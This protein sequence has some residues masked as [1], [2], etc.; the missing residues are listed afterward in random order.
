MEVNDPSHQGTYV[1]F[2]GMKS[3]LK[4]CP[5]E[6]ISSPCADYFQGPWKRRKSI[7]EMRNSPVTARE[8]KMEYPMELSFLP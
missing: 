6:R 2:W 5:A 3:G 4:I 8:K 7:G 1:G